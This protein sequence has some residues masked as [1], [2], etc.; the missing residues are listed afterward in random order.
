MKPIATHSYIIITRQISWEEQ[1]I[2]ESKH[3]IVLYENR[4]ADQSQLFYLN[5]VLDVSFKS[6]NKG[7]G[8]LY[9]HTVKGLFPYK[10]KEDP[11]AF[12]EKYKE[13]RSY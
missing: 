9:V 7:Y 11:K 12:I 8:F 2:I 6:I 4:I 10:V 5:E 1:H 3:E 13:L